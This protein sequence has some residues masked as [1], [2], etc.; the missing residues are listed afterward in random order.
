MSDNEEDLKLI[1][2]IAQGDARA[3]EELFQR[4]GRRLGGYLSRRL[5]RWELVDECYSDVMVATWQNAARFEEGRIVRAWLFGIARNKASKCFEHRARR[6]DLSA[7]LSEDGDWDPPQDA[8][9]GPE[10]RL[11]ARDKLRWVL[12]AICD[13]PPRMREVLELVWI[14]GLRYTEIGELLGIS[15]NTVKTRVFHAR[16]RLPPLD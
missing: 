11:V 4:H 6:P 14:D 7:G 13:L 2:R 5:Q 10:Q 3:L 12:K 8:E 16:R 15:P 1:R 9:S